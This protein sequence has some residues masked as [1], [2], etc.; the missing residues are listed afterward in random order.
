MR[1]IHR[2]CVQVLFG[3]IFFQL[4]FSALSNS[5]AA[6]EKNILI[7]HSYHQGYKWTDDASRGIMSALSPMAKD[8][9]FY[10]EYMGSKW[11]SEVSFSEQLRDVFKR[12]YA[13]IPLDVIITTDNDAF[14]F[15]R[16]YRDE[17]FG[18][19]PVV[20]CGVNWLK[21]ED[22][23]G[24]PLY[25]GVN[26]DA[27]IKENIDLM[28]R[29]HPKTTDV[30]VIAD[31]TT[32][33]QVIH[34]KLQEVLPLYTGRVAFHVLDDLASS[35]VLDKVSSLSSNSLVLITIFQKDKLGKFLEFNE[36]AQ[37]VSQGSKVPVYGLWDFHLGYGIVG[38]MLTSGYA[39]GAAAGEIALRVLNGVAPDAIPIVMKSPNS[40]MFDHL[41]LQRFGIHQEA[42]PEGSI[43]INKPVSFYS[44]HELLLDSVLVVFLVLIGFVVVL[45]TNIKRRRSLELQLRQAQISLEARVKDRTDELSREK[46]ALWESEQTQR[47]LMDALPAGVVI[48]DPVSRV[49]ESV[50]NYVANLF[51]GPIDSLIGKRCHS[52]LCPAEEGSCPVCDLGK[53]VDNSEKIMLKADGSR[54]PILKTVKRISINGQERLLEC[55]VDISDRKQAE[56]KLQESQEQFVL[57][58]HGSNDGIWDWDLQSNSLFLS[59]RWKEQVGYR[60]DELKNAFASFEELIHPDD[61]G[62]VLNYVQE[63]LKGGREQYTQELRL[64]HKD[65]SYRWILARGAAVFGPDGKPVRMAGSHTDITDS[66]Q[67]EIALREKSL[68]FELI[69]SNSNVGI[70]V[71]KGGRIINRGNQRLADIL[72]YGT[73]QEMSGLSVRALHLSEERFNA[74]GKQHYE[75]LSEGAQFQVEYQLARKDGSPVWCSL[76]GTAFDRHDLSRG[77]IWVIDDLE[78]RKKAE[79]ALQI[80]TDFL[81]TLQSAMPVPVFYKGLDGKYLGVN[82]AFEDFFKTTEKDFIGKTVFDIVSPETALILDAQDK[83]LYA[84]GGKLVYPTEVKNAVGDLRHVI[85]YKAVFYTAGRAAGLIGVILDI[86]ELKR[87]EA[88]LSKARDEA[89]AAALAKSQFLANM[90]HEIR[91]PMNAILGFSSLLRTTEL[92]DK[93]L[94]HVNMILSNGKMLLEIINDIL[95]VSKFES[96]H[97]SLESVDFNLDYL[98]RDV[99]GMCL[100]KIEEKPIETYVRIEHDVLVNLKGD[101][102]RLRQVL[103]NLV[104]NAIKFTTSGSIGIKVFKDNEGSLD[105]SVALRVHVVDTGIGIAQDKVGMIFEPFIQADGSTTRKYGGTGLGLSISKAIVHAYG[106]KIWVESEEGKG[107]EF[108]FT[109]KLK[110]GDQ[111]STAGIQPVSLDKLKGRRVVIVDDKAANREILQ[112]YCEGAGMVI[113]G[114]YEKPALAVE[115]IRLMCG[116]NDVPDIVLSDLMMPEMDGHQ[117]AESIKQI[118]DIK[119]VVVTSDA[120]I[121]T[122]KEAENC[123]FDGYI[124][125]PFAREQFYKVLVTVLGDTREGG[126]IVTRHMAEELSCKGVKILV[127]EDNMANRM[128]MEEYLQMLEC[129]YDFAVN[130]QEA[131]DKLRGKTY[132]LC[133]MDVQMPEM[134]GLEATRII[135]QEMSK[136]FPVIALSA[137][138][139]QEDKEKGAEAGMTDYLNKPVSF[140]ELKAVVVKWK[141]AGKGKM[142][143]R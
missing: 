115:A 118:R 60:D 28:L 117:L 90:S 14:D 124:A 122:A 55:F 119:L 6:G 123:G 24:H 106:G 3:F 2:I 132:D 107:S 57:A 121:G 103:V 43:V 48:V 5:Y 56:K 127:A 34:R 99:L 74:F 85:Y 68:E 96:G 102:S 72:G 4:L 64:R 135:R 86:T 8:A 91:T 139:M 93:Q 15:L 126:A 11:V 138:V 82:A 109:L 12:R 76:S 87:V 94:R 137:A 22:L 53:D 20:F 51:G 19:V 38:G 42:L 97:I 1:S 101:P 41:Q 131:V 125:K 113:S 81:Q 39:Q 26:E 77:V 25:T 136:D 16:K 140:P 49:I 44:E 89:N 88:A 133:L 7:V 110:A 92:T 31:L 47:M 45:L 120:R 143:D 70:M 37:Q 134:S 40:Y 54:L 67:A 61:R 79:E 105:G 142:L 35:Q 128:L 69:F 100:S 65:G 58:V 116:A 78:P 32:T 17:M 36:I 9:K 63:Y 141:D 114:V 75:K 46:E 50:N 66:K 83:E 104:G 52:L 130:G 62:R 129:E 33:G 111:G 80:R 98:C 18:I 71:L 21:P 59:P 10:Y 29:L 13:N 23:Q 30:Y 84:R 108:I 27:D 95:D 112:Y 73:P